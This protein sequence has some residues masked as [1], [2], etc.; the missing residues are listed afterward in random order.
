VAVTRRPGRGAPAWFPYQ[1]PLY[2]LGLFA[3]TVALAIWQ[4]WSA[5]DLV[6]GLWISSLLVGYAFIV[7]T[8]FVGNEGG[9]EGSIPTVAVTRATPGLPA[10]GRWVM[11]LFLLGFFTV[12]F[13]GFHFVHGLFLNQFFPLVSESAGSGAGWIGGFP[14]IVRTA[15]E[16]YWPFLAATVLSRRADFRRSVEADRDAGASLSGPYR[17]VVRMHLLIFVFAGLEA[18]GLS[19]YALYPVLFFY[20]FPLGS[21]KEMLGIGG[22]APER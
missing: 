14:E 17:N 20:F 13:G 11:G 1:E 12:H 15:L 19:G 3:G 10:A 22:D 4:D 2:D 21:V 16:R 18:A 5:T 6:W 9:G 7:V 8:I